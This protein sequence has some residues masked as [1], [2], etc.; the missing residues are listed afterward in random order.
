MVAYGY[1]EM[2]SPNPSSLSVVSSSSV[3]TESVSTWDRQTK[4]SVHSLHLGRF[5]LSSF[6]LSSFFQTSTYY[7]RTQC[8]TAGMRNCRLQ[9]YKAVKNAAR[10]GEASMEVDLQH[11]SVM[12]MQ[13]TLG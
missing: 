7:P 9:K 2:F 6:F 8:A 1:R 3:E 10:V 11:E 4:V 12:H 13:M 5:F